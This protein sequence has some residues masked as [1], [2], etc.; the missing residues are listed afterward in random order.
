M[1]ARSVSSSQAGSLCLS[2]SVSALLLGANKQQFYQP[3]CDPATL[4][5]QFFELGESFANFNLATPVFDDVQLLIDLYWY[6][7]LVGNVKKIAFF[8]QRAVAS[9]ISIGL[10]DEGDASWD[11]LSGG[12]REERRRAAESVLGAAR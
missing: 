3:N 1:E 11:E 10:L 2:I 4:H 7:V 12:Q 6:S 8:L 9:S 5:A